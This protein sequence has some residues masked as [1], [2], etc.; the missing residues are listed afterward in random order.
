[1][2]VLTVLIIFINLEW[3]TVGRA[4]ETKTRSSDVDLS[5]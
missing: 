5:V 3:P 4:E 2:S 1:M